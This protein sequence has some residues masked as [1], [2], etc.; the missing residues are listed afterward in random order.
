MTKHDI[1]NKL[2]VVKFHLERAHKRSLDL[3]VCLIGVD[4]RNDLAYSIAK[5][6]EIDRGMVPDIARLKKGG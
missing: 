5:I 2:S 6:E 4:V 3:G 1:I